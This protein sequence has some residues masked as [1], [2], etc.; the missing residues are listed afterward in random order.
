MENEHADLFSDK[1][2]RKSKNRRAASTN[3]LP[4]YVTHGFVQPFMGTLK[5][6][7]KYG[8]IIPFS[9][10]HYKIMSTKIEAPIVKRKM[11]SS[12]RIVLSGLRVSVLWYFR[13]LGR[14]Y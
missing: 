12:P 10:F 4:E 1:T 11:V 14:L 13:Q 8:D 5:N 2:S 9:H 6:T 3:L 7:Y